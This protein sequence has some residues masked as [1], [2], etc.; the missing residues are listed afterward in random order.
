MF[1]IMTSARRFRKLVT[2]WWGSCNKDYIVFG[3]YIGF[4]LSMETPRYL[5]VVKVL[6]DRPMFSLRHALPELEKGGIRFR[7]AG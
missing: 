3:V 4:P 1:L 5:P 6:L 7:L 2:L